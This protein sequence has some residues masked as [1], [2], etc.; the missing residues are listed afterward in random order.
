MAQTKKTA[1]V[2]RILQ[3]TL[4]IRILT[5]LMTSEKTQA[6]LAKLTETNVVY[7]SQQVRKLQK[8]NLI[9]MVKPQGCK[10]FTCFLNE[11]HRVEIAL[12]LENAHAITSFYHSA[13]GRGQ[14]GIRTSINH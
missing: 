7:I 8:A 10:R 13:G 9:Q 4:N 14:Y 3:N 2:F 5:L 6:T 12:L 11:R 1:A